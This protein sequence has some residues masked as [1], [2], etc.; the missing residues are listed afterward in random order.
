M[1]KLLSCMAIAFLFHASV[2]FASEVDLTKDGQMQKYISNIGFHILNSNRIEKKMSFYYRQDSKNINATASC[3]DRSIVFHRGLAVYLDSEDE[4][5]AVLAHE[6]SHGVDFYDGIFRG[7]FSG[8]TNYIEPRKY[9]RKADKRA[10]DYMVQAGYNPV[11]LIVVM[12]KTMPQERYEIFSTHPL[13]SRRMMYV[14]EY[15]YNK[16]P[17]YLANNVYK[18]NVYYQNFLLTS[19]VNRQKFQ[20]S[21]ENPTKRNKTV[22]YL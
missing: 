17:E 13:T 22:Q 1:K 16:Y 4:F 3:R 5:A 15:I 8:L 12:N 21:I 10:I 9:E 19:R 20:K 6:I 2:V 7:Y 14:Y 11:A 18:N